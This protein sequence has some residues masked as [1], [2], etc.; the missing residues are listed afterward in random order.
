MAK[1]RFSIFWGLILV[2]AI[3]W[4]LA[5]L[6]VIA[7]NIPWLPIILVVIAFGAFINHLIGK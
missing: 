3:V 5:D 2:L 1:G 6:E 4:L 7:I